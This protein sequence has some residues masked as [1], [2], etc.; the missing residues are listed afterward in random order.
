MWL[1]LALTSNKLVGRGSE[2]SFL[3]FRN[4][5]SFFIATGFLRILMAIFPKS[6]QNFLGVKC[7]SHISLPRNLVFLLTNPF[8]F[9]T[10]I[11]SRFEISLRP[12]S[13]SFARHL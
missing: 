2:G 8:V 6:V 1:D 11:K 13:H 5:T 12:K 7:S 9:E 4:G 3:P 10:K